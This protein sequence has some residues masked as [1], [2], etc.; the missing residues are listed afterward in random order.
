[1]LEPSRRGFLRGLG[2]LFA[3][4]AIVRVESLMKVVA[5]KL[6]IPPPII[7]AGFDPLIH[8][9]LD[10]EDFGPYSDMLGKEAIATLEKMMADAYLLPRP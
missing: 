5:P 1:M 3:A 2:A 10:Y 9:M 7:R 8:S 6:I 4:P